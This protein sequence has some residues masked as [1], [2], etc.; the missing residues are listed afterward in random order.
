MA[1][2]GPISLTIHFD[3]IATFRKH[4]LVD[5]LGEVVWEALGDR[6]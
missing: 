6:A 4:D 5:A 1:A 2:S 3:C